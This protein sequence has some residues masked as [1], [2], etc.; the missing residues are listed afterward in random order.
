MQAPVF[1]KT[2]ELFLISKGM[3]IG[4]LLNSISINNGFLSAS[5]EHMPN[6]IKWMLTR[7]KTENYE[8]KID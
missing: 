3:L 5:L 1:K 7:F 2:A 8:Y 6:T 4:L